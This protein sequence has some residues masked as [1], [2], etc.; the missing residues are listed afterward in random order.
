M[1]FRGRGFSQLGQIP[2]TEQALN[3]L[4]IKPVYDIAAG[5]KLQWFP[6]E[7]QKS[8]VTFTYSSA[9]IKGITAALDG[10]TS[11]QIGAEI[12]T[13][14]QKQDTIGGFSFGDDTDLETIMYMK[15]KSAFEITQ[16]FIQAAF[17]LNI[18]AWT[19][20]GVVFN[21]VTYEVRLYKGGNLTNFNVI[22]RE[23]VPTGHA[24]LGAVGTNIFILQAQFSGESIEPSDTIGIYFKC[25]N[26]QTATNTYQSLLLPI[27]AF[28]ETDFTKT[29][30][31]SGVMTHMLPSFDAASL[32]IK[33]ELL[34]WPIDDFGSPRV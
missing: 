22:A 12:P 28:S 13:I 33:H 18:S 23:V 25:N 19:D 3:R 26:T 5:A 20:N 24:S 29:F 9:T 21:D 17:A 14:I 31:Q 16:C 27:F 32:A 30:Y 4:S 10:I 15:P 8:G 6:F 2:P 7:L 34:N 11:Y 1:S